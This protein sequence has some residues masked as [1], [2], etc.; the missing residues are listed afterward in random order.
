M[1]QGNFGLPGCFCLDPAQAVGNLVHMAVHTNCI[2]LIPQI[3][4]EIRGL[5]PH[6][7]QCKQLLPCVGY[8]AIVLC[9]QD[10]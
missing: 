8:P 3:Q 5:Y 7:R 4:G 1:L 9:Y 10:F 6:P 2:N